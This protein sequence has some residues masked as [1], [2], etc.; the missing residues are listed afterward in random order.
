[1]L[2]WGCGEQG[3][4]PTTVDPGPDFVVA[5]VVFDDQ[6]FYCRVEPLIF[7]QRCGPGNSGQDPASGCHFNV[8]SYRLTDYSPL[9]ADRCNGDALGPGAVVTQQAR[10][11]YQTSQARMKRDPEL[12]QL[13]LRPTGKAKHPRVVVDLDTPEGAAYDAAVRQWATQFSSQ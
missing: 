11:N 9:V 1:L 6:F 13:L 10:Q 12:A 5:D 4:L 8:T 3:L 7:Q 2:L